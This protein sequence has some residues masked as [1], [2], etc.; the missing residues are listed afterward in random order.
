MK[1][2]DKI[3]NLRTKGYSYNEIKNELGCAKSSISY[4]CK[5]IDDDSIKQKNVIIKNKKQV[6]DD[7]F[8]LNEVNVDLIIELRKNKVSYDEIKEKTGYS[9]HVI[10]KVCRVYNLIGSRRFSNIDDDMILSINIFYKKYRSTR[11]VALELNISRD[12]VRKYLNDENIELLG[13]KKIKKVSG[14]TAVVDWRK[15]TKVKLVEYKGG[16]CSK[17]GY[18]KSMNVLQFHHLD[19][20]KKDFTIGGKSWSYERLKEEVDKCILV[21]ANCHIEIHEEQNIL[22]NTSP[23]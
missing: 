8:L 11:K 7:N 6:K 15:R 14:S 5:N 13:S 2:K 21:C 1:L 17:C 12:S 9:L 3:I 22:V 20:S 4:H 10:S 16:C 19:P 23:T 18:N